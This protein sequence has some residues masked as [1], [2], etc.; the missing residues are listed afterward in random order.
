ML[1]IPGERAPDC[2]V[3]RQKTER[4]SKMLLSK[5]G[6]SAKQGDFLAGDM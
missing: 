1:V 2:W 3:A 6:I 4:G 5:F